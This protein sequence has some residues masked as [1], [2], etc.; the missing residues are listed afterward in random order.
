MIPLTPSAT[1]P[2]EVATKLSN[3]AAITIILVI[4]TVLLTPRKSSKKPA[5]SL[6]ALFA[7]ATVAAKKMAA[8]LP[9]GKVRR[10]VLANPIA[11]TPTEHNRTPNKK[12]SQNIPERSISYAV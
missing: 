4:Y 5:T 7:I 9:S 8:A 1:A 11:D 10:N 3:V 6:P 2:V 12:V